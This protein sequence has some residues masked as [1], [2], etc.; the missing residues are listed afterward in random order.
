LQNLKTALSLTFPGI[1]RLL[2]EQCANNVAHRFISSPTAHW[3]TSACLDDWGQEFALFLAKVPELESIPYLMDYANYEWQR[4][5]VFQ[6]PN[7]K[8][9]TKAQLLELSDLAMQNCEVTFC[10]CVFFYC[11][12]YPIDKIV[13]FVD[14]MQENTLQIKPQPVYAVIYRANGQ[15]ITHWITVDLWDFL[16]LLTQCRFAQ[17]I[18]KTYA[19][20]PD[21]DLVQAFQFLL[22]TKIICQLHQGKIAHE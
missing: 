1:W 21:F 14:T 5:Q 11:A 3:P 18:A 19:Q 12:A 13:S 16:K 8:A 10:A 9:L 7:T 6:A 22:E 17:A 2:G 20:Y 4:H 15:L